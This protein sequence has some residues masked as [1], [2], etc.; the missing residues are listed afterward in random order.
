MELSISEFAL[1]LVFDR[2][3]IHAVNLVRPLAQA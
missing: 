1:G 3:G 2:L